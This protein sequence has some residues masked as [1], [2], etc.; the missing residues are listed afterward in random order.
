MGS[1]SVLARR[2][3]A[4]HACGIGIEIPIE[5]LVGDNGGRGGQIDPMGEVL[6]AIRGGWDMGDVDVLCKA[7]QTLTREKEVHGILSAVWICD[8]AVG[9]GSGGH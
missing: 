2:H 8:P 1:S 6:T 9:T 3:C 5:E 7:D 4:L